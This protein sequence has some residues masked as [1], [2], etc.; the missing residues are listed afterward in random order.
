MFLKVNKK[1]ALIIGSNGF[2]GNNVFHT[3]TQERLDLNLY[4]ISRGFG[5]L[6]GKNDLGTDDWRNLSSQNINMFDF[7]IFSS[8]VPYQNRI[9]K[10]TSD[11]VDKFFHDFR[12]FCFN[13]NLNVQDKPKKFIFFSSYDYSPSAESERYK[14]FQIKD[15]IGE[16]AYNHIDKS[17]I[18][19][20]KLP[21]LFGFNSNIKV[22]NGFINTIIVNTICENSTQIFGDVLINKDYCYIDI[23]VSKIIQ[24]LKEERFVGKFEFIQQNFYNNLEIA[25]I[26]KNKFKNT[27]NLDSKF[28]YED[29]NVD[30]TQN[31]EI[32]ASFSLELDRTIEK[33]MYKLNP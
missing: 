15:K 32:S 6:N 1:N 27:Y 8:S 29:L 7:I 24:S 12:N 4:R 16:I 33:Y 5:N 30:L 3:L 20:F 25:T 10:N 23:L 21:N 22:G 17:N 13:F 26:L 31:I 14:Y 9:K 18:L 19:E 28:L 2:I 11:E